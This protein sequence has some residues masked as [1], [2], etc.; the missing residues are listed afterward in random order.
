M[1]PLSL[2][3]QSG[4]KSITRRACLL[5]PLGGL[6]FACRWWLGRKRSLPNPADNG[7]GEFVALVIFSDQ[8]KCLNRI[9]V[10]K[11]LQTP[12]MWRRDLD[13]EAFAVTREQATEFAFHNL[14]WNNQRPGIYRC[15]CCGNALFR[16]KDKYDSGT[17]WPSFSAPIAGENVTSQVDH[18]LRLIRNEVICRKCDAH[19][20][21]LFDDGP[22]PAYKRYC[23]N[24]AALRF[25]PI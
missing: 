11:L 6:V 10:R 17:G 5:A 18:S 15:V 21:H 4:D 16:S 12:S 20:G 1:E 24:S 22:P 23:L 2:L 25:V 13:P 7:N 9:H 19:L 8:G 14:Y 3:E